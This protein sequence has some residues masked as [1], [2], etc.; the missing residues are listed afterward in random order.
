MPRALRIVRA[1]RGHDRAKVEQE[2]GIGRGSLAEYE[3][4]QRE[5]DGPTIRKIARALGVSETTLT[6]L[7]L[8][9]EKREESTD[10]L[11]VQVFLELLR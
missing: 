7:S 8:P 10:Q 11:A 9:R 4:G 2:A 3:G 1:A 6:T 5:P